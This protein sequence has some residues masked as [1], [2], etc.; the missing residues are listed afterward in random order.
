MSTPSGIRGYVPAVQLFSW[1]LAKAKALSRGNAGADALFTTPF[2]TYSHSVALC[3]TL[4]DVEKNGESVV[5]LRL[6]DPTGICMVHIDGRDADLQSAAAALEA[7]CFVYVFGRLRL[8]GQMPLI[9]VI[10]AETVQMISRSARDSWIIETAAKA[11]ARLASCSDES[12]RT[13]FSAAVS[14]A[15]DAAAPAK[16]AAV[17]HSPELSDEDV[18]SLIKSLYEGKAAPRTKVINALI[19]KG[20]TSAE[21]ADRIHHLM[22]EGDLYAPRADILKI[23]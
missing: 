12:L 16:T 1:E 9:P 10:N 14:A 19:E 23:L 11:A 6:S 20:L 2:G 3:G 7:P 4:T 15:L 18:L 22:D 17:P 21:A 13:E 5:S 8:S